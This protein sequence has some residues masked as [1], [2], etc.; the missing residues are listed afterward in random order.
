MEE[1]T[2]LQAHQ[3]ALVRLLHSVGEFA[4]RAGQ[5]PAQGAGAG[6]D[7]AERY[8]PEPWREALQPLVREPAAEGREVPLMTLAARLAAGEQSGTQEARP[9]QLRSIFSALVLGEQR[10]EPGAY[11]YWPL[12]PLAL[13]EEVIFP[14]PP[15]PEAEVDKAYARLWEGF[16]AEV[17]TLSR[18]HSGAED[19][20]VY[21]ESLLL[22]LQ[23]YAWCVP[24]AGAGSLRDVSLYD[25][26][27]TAAALAVCLAAQEEPTLEALLEA[28]E[29]SDE[30]VALLVGGDLSGVQDFIYTITSK[31][32]AGALRGRSFYLQLLTEAVARYILREL[33][34]PAT[35]LLY[36]G[37]GNFYL[38][39]RV[40]DAERLDEIHRQLSHIL[41]AH[42]RGELYLALA[43]EPLRAS[44]FFAGRI[45]GKWDALSRRQQQAKQ[46]RF[47]ELGT[48]L[49]YLFAP[50]GEG[51]TEHEE[52]N[53]CGR[54][55]PQIAEDAESG[56]RKCRP[57]REFEALG[58][59]LRAAEFL[60]L[61]EVEPAALPDNPLELQPGDWQA[62]LKS[63][64]LRA[65][66]AE[67]LQEIPQRKGERRV[68]LALNDAALRDLEP[69]PH[70]VVGRRFLVN[71]TPTL[72]QADL[73]A[74]GKDL[75]ETLYPG[76]VKP[77]SALE[78]Q[79]T[80]IRRLG[81]LRM[82]V[83]NLGTLFSEGFGDSAT[84]ARV[85]ALS[86][87]I[88][89][90]FEGW[91]AERA[92][93]I[94]EEQPPE[95]GDILYSIYSGGDD[96][97]FVGA[98]DAVVELAREIRVDLTRFAGGHPAIHASAGL[99]LVGGKYPLYQAAADAGGAEHAAKQH[100][101]KDAV[102]FLGQTLSWEKFGL[103][104]SCEEGTRTV[105]GLR[106]RLERLVRPQ[107]QQG[108]G[109]STALL[110]RLIQL[111][112][113]YEEALGKNQQAG[114][115]VN[116]SGEVQGVWGPW[117][118]RGYYS[119]KRMAQRAQ[120]GEAKVA[121]ETL[122]ETLHDDNFKGI[123]WIGLAARWV[124]LGLR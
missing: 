13:E 100:P 85:M 74:V 48:D 102:T 15:R 34:L 117:M 25:H 51:G 52:C 42:H 118:W 5:T 11:R 33:N 116:R 110:R 97:F 56:T 28:P 95:R 30:P 121:I 9:R 72:R 44:D 86:F 35:N 4:R 84:L 3:L 67:H 54:E 120:E 101:G 58:K 64:G 22:L 55:H 93:R 112:I 111:Q 66:V 43:S 39:A 99:A 108:L 89:L 23:R 68:V 17:E 123:G 8:V 90:F 16:R 40:E 46:R 75:D 49:A 78:L 19:L 65:G 119:L 27:R 104:E 96:L 76:G 60:W 73:E 71:V 83:D 26:G 80:G 38:L 82:D 79:A 124:E 57:C 69:G 109:V 81:V 63:L 105:H 14:Q 53:V 29:A 37:G 98:W 10:L 59:D 115:D 88:G 7:F 122:A 20:P 24:S 18:I 107:A 41:L 87:T 94:N 113:Q 103:E 6:A 45:A 21:L 31:G 50:Q 36:Q 77:F 12:E 1:R 114:T 47:V 62:V 106:H 91:V 92:Q 70:T 61:E 32:A 2:S